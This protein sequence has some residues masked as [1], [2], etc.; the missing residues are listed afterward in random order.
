M[1]EKSKKASFSDIESQILATEIINLRS[2]IEK[3]T[4]SD[5]VLLSQSDQLKY[6]IAALSEGIMELERRLNNL[7]SHKRMLLALH[8]GTV[9]ALAL[10]WFF[11][12][13]N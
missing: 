12:V 13:L 9:V 3:M 2:A 7:E 6:Q 5:T 10:L 4:V 1:I 8:V 11:G